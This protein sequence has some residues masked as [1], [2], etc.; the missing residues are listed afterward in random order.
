[1]PSAWRPS[2]GSCALQLPK[3]TKSSRA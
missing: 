1:M 2:I 3:L